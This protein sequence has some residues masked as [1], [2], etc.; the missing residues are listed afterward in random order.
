MNFD[1]GSQFN[2]KHH[3]NEEKPSKVDLGGI[4]PLMSDGLFKSHHKFY[5]VRS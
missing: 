3:P 4:R 1:G 5:S 2:L